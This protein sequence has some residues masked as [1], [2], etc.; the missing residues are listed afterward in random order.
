VELAHFGENGRDRADTLADI[1]IM[2]VAATARQLPRWPAGSVNQISCFSYPNESKSRVKPLVE[3][4]F[5]RGELGEGAGKL[6]RDGRLDPRIRERLR[7]LFLNIPLYLQKARPLAF[8]H[9]E[10]GFWKNMI[11]CSPPT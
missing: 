7:W 2:A 4:E 8:G 11:G 5:T 9:P 10:I 6:T 3:I 1:G